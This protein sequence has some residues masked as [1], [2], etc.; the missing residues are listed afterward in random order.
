[1]RPTRAHMF[2]ASKRLAAK[3]HMPPISSMLPQEQEN[4]EHAL[5]H[6]S[7]F[8]CRK[9]NT[10]NGVQKE[11]KTRK[12]GIPQREMQP[13]D[14]PPHKRID[15]QPLGLANQAQWATRCNCSSCQLL[16][17]TMALRS[18]CEGCGGLVRLRLA[19]RKMTRQ[20]Q[21]SCFHVVH[22]WTLSDWSF[23]CLRCVASTQRCSAFIT[24]FFLDMTIWMTQR[25]MVRT[26]SSPFWTCQ[27]SF[28][29]PSVQLK[30]GDSFSRKRCSRL[31]NNLGIFHKHFAILSSAWIC[32]QE[33][34]SKWWLEDCAFCQDFKGKWNSWGAEQLGHW[35]LASFEHWQTN[36]TFLLHRPR[37]SSTPQWHHS[38]LISMFHRI[39]NMTH[40]VCF[41]QVCSDLSDAH[42]VDRF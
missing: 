38:C 13:R 18:C 31:S 11:G 26:C 28:L 35:G 33:S 14:V 19:G 3:C 21:L 29:L 17:V 30:L 7:S 27:R 22:N 8:S 39:V 5:S 12:R 34:F 41:A 25:K 15:N 16:V 42:F 1:M 9:R 23:W 32:W 4:K 2:E 37:I 24:F 40:L 20:K 10:G 6:A 36:L